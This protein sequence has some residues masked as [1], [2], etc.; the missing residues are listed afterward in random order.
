MSKYGTRLSL[1]LSNQRGVAAKKSSYSLEVASE[2]VRASVPRPSD[3]DDDDDDDDDE[4]EEEEEG[5]K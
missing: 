4:E 3:D 5:K 2:K 1:K